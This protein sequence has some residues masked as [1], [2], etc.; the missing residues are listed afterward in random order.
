MILDKFPVEY[1]PENGARIGLLPRGP[2]GLI[3]TS[4]EVKWFDCKV[5][6]VLHTINA[7]ETEDGQ[8]L[9]LHAFRATPSTEGSYMQK[10]AP[11]CLYEWVIDLV[12]GTLS[13]QYLNPYTLVEFP[14]INDLRRRKELKYSYGLLDY[15]FGGPL[16]EVV[17]APH[18]GF[19]FNGVVKF[20]MK[21][22]P[23][24]G[25]RKGDVF[26]QFIL[27]RNWYAVSEACLVPKKETSATPGR[28]G[29]SDQDSNENAYITLLATYIPPDGRSFLEIASDETT[30]KSHFLILDADNMAAGPVSAVE[31]P[32]SV[33]YGLHSLFLEWDKHV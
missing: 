6:V 30:M 20:T 21:D 27:P 28:G 19:T 14:T 1:E 5:G 3:D 17:S 2:D 7:H 9:V 22:D 32:V 16:T 15:G 26:D 33:R 11:S 31:L 8:S 23:G 4:Q 13:E 10:N 25:L 24:R 18:D 29:I 12:N